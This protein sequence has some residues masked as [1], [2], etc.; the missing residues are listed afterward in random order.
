M[1]I[2][3]ILNNPILGDYRCNDCEENG[4]GVSF[5]ADIQREDYVIIKIDHYFNKEIHPNPDGNDCLVVQ[6]CG[7]N[8][9]KLYLIELKSIESLKSYSLE[10]IRKKFQNC[11]DIFMSDKFRSYFYDLNH[12]FASIQLIFISNTKEQMQRIDKKQKNTRLD[13]LLALPPCR[14]GNKLYGIEFQEPYPTIMP[15]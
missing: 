13:S 3:D 4:I 1:L 7:D 15:C 10:Q 12:D 2:N 6:K 14:F 9:Y 5:H 11:F 8:R